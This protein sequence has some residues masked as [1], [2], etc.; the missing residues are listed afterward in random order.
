MPDMH[1]QAVSST[2]YSNLAPAIR[3]ALYDGID[4]LIQI[5]EDAGPLSPESF[6]RV[7]L[8]TLEVCM[9][10][11][12]RILQEI[13][14]YRGVQL[15]DATKQDGRALRRRKATP[16]TVGAGDPGA[17]RPAAPRPSMTR[18]VSG[19]NPFVSAARRKRRR[20]R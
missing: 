20:R 12:R 19:E 9:D 6:E 3:D 11:K 5:Q 13:L 4:R 10:M 2:D 14:E 8:Q 18:G 7:E 16:K 15:P 17:R 1:K